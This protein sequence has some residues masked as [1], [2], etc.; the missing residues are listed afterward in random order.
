MEKP[1][2]TFWPTQQLQNTCKRKQVLNCYTTKRISS[3]QKRTVTE[4]M[5]D[6]SL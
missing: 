2:E 3:T 5:R 6:K 4:E 1:K